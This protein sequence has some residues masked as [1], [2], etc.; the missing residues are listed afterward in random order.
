MVVQHLEAIWA[1]NIVFHSA[2][3]RIYRLRD[4]CQSDCGPFR[5]SAAIYDGSYAGLFKLSRLRVP[6]YRHIFSTFSLAIL[7]LLCVDR[8]P[9]S[10]HRRV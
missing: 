7:L 9:P 4:D 8:P 5:R 6:R 10:R 2:Y 1:G 3:D